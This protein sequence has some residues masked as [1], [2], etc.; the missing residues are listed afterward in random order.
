MNK[1][2]KLRIHNITAKA[3]LKFG[4][5]AWVLKKREEQ[6]LEATQ[7]GF[8][9]HLLGITKLDKEENQCIRQ[10]TGAQNIV[11]EIKQYQEKWLQH[12]QRMDTNRL[13]KQHYNINQ[14]DEGTKDDRGRD[15]GTNFI[16]RIKEQ[17]TRLTLQEHD[18]DDDAYTLS[19]PCWW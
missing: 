9:R 14:K 8:L 6:R 13:P 19:F 18:D 2:T 5:E 7:M 17:E 12:I 4:C 3:T 16:L 1:E 10:K 15:G 11:K